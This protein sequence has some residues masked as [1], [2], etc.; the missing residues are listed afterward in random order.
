VDK[1]ED[2]I[3]DDSK[4]GTKGLTDG[5]NELLVGR[6]VSSVPF[7]TNGVVS[8]AKLDLKLVDCFDV[9]VEMGF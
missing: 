9:K 6:L 3:M 4:V 2:I 7:V 8:F 5:F 1:L